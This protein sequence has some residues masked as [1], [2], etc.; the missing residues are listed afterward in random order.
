MCR[1]FAYKGNS[2][3]ELNNLY[4]ALRE[5]ARNDTIGSKFG[6]ANHPDGFGYVIYNGQHIYYYRSANP[7]YEENV[8]LPEVTGDMYAIFLARKASGKKHMGVMYSH[9]F[10]DDYSNNLLY[11][12][13][14]GSVSEDEL[15][16]ELNYRYD[17]SDSELALKYISKYGINSDSINNL[18]KNYT[19]SSLNLL[20]LSIPKSGT[21]ESLYY[22]NYYINK[23]KHDYSDMYSMHFNHGDAVI[24]STLRLHGINTDEKV[25]F[26][27]LMEL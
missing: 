27:K 18:M 21:E 25:T 11:L 2:Q 1:M 7:I 9:P 20:I 14:N 5:S 26:G 19:T 16:K 17:A 13:H 15:K 24:S 3:E 22:L 10:M 8:K 12:A 4:N 23:D 6:Y